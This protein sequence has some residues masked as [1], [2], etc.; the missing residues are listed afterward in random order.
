MRLIPVWSTQAPGL[1]ER[2]LQA[3]AEGWPRLVVDPAR[4]PLEDV[5]VGPAVVDVVV[6]GAA[7]VEEAVVAV[8]D[9]VAVVEERRAFVHTQPYPLRCFSIETNFLFH[10]AGANRCFVRLWW[11]INKLQACLGCSII[12]CT[13]GYG[14]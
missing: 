7:E 9:V 12:P 14:L 11:W 3:P 2:A 4:A 6:E 13:D 10:W 8:V 5:A 1:P